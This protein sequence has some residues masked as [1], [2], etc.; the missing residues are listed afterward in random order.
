VVSEPLDADRSHWTPVPPGYMLTAL[1]GK[2]ISLAPML[3]ESRVAA[4]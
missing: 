3:A 1:A 4:E 2:P